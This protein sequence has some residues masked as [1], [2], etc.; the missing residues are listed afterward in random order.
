VAEGELFDG[1]DGLAQMLIARAAPARFD[2]ASSTPEQQQIF[3]LRYA[4]VVEEG[5]VPDSAYPNGLE[6]DAFDD[7]ATHIAGWQDAELVAT[8]RLVFP[9]TGRMLPTE[10]EF[11]LTVEPEGAVVDI[12]RAIVARAYRAR[13]HT[14]FGALLSRCWLEIRKRGYVNLCGAASGWR[15]ERYRQ[16]GLPL[17]TIGPPRQ[18]W[19]EERYPVFLEGRE[20]ATFAR[21]YTALRSATTS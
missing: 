17:R 12:G 19:G 4:T 2:V 20:F 9:E 15:L 11:E 3:A 21:P 14:L 6:R 1:L 13:D 16:F 5:W 10:L 7:S 8:A 18:Y